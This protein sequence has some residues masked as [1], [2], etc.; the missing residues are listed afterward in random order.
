MLKVLSSPRAGPKFQPPF[1]LSIS[2]GSFGSIRARFSWVPTDGQLPSR[3]H[4]QCD[5]KWICFLFLFFVSV[6]CN[7][8]FWDLVGV[9]NTARLSISACCQ[10]G[11]ARDGDLVALPRSNHSSLA[12]SK[13]LVFGIGYWV[14]GFGFSVQFSAFSFERSFVGLACCL[15]RRFC[16]EISNE[17]LEMLPPN[18]T[19]HAEFIGILISWNFSV[20]EWGTRNTTNKWRETHKRDHLGNKCLSYVNITLGPKWAVIYPLPFNSLFLFSIFEKLIKT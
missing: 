16:F 8:F 18:R 4:S 10:L 11:G 7:F 9:V 5:P 12:C 20:W 17:M 2:T 6:F 14:L 1:Q 19:Q 15:S 3:L 13:G